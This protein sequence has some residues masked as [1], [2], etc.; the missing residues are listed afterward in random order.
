MLF[1]GGIKLISCHLQQ[2]PPKHSSPVT[3]ISPIS[4]QTSSPDSQRR[5]SRQ[6]SIAS[7]MSGG[8]FSTPQTQFLQKTKEMR[9][10]QATSLNS[11]QTPTPTQSQPSTPGAT[12][13]SPDKP[14]IPPRGNPP[15]VP[16][17][18]ISSS[19]SV[20]LRNRSGI[21][22]CSQFRHCFFSLFPSH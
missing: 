5:S 7:S 19:E 8:S 11:P 22:D 12:I 20:Q 14:P 15:P 2:T 9:E 4:S 17:R 18:Q 10:Q 21:K 16:Q 1:D 6:D 3:E 13:Y